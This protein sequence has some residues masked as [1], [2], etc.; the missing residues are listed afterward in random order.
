KPTAQSRYVWFPSASPHEILL[1]L[2]LA[3]RE[4]DRVGVRVF[5]VNDAVMLAD[6]PF[7]FQVVLLRF[8][9]PGPRIGLGV[10]NRYCNLQSIRMDSSISF[11]EVHRITVRIA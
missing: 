6:F 10:I 7:R 11:G 2:G 3:G 5:F 1:L 4:A 8:I 9:D